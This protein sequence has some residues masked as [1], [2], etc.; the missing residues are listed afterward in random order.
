[1]ALPGAMV[2]SFQSVIRSPISF[3]T[4]RGRA[5]KAS[6]A[7]SSASRAFITAFWFLAVAVDLSSLMAFPNLTFENG[8]PEK[9]VQI[10]LIK[11]PVC[12][13]L[14]YGEA[15][16]EAEGGPLSFGWYR[17]PQVHVGSRVTGLS[18]QHGSGQRNQRRL[19]Q[20]R[21][22]DGRALPQLEQVLSKC[23]GGL[24]RGVGDQGDKAT[25]QGDL[26]KVLLEL[27]VQGTTEGS[28]EEVSKLRPGAG[29]DGSDCYG[30]GWSRL[31]VVSSS[32]QCL[33][34][35]SNPIVTHATSLVLTNTMTR[36]LSLL[37]SSSF[38]RTAVLKTKTSPSSTL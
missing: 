36:P 17:P 27:P 30:R 3:R 25:G 23:G 9:P 20:I 11:R 32:F 12:P 8:R 26:I 31:C 2:P 19:R 37:C 4:S 16:K 21:L 28:V 29:I 7:L 1:M 6:A 22:D 14:L 33:R 35:L 13:A 34:Q 38:S 15:V 24:L 5:L 18:W 10:P